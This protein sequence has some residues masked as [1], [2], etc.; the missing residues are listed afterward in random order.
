[1]LRVNKLLRMNMNRTKSG[2]NPVL[3]IHGITD[4]TLVFRQMTAYLS[5]QGFS[6]HSFD[7]TPNNGAMPLD[8][9][10]VQVADYIAKSFDPEQPLDLIGFSMGGIVSRYY[11]QRLGGLERVQRFISIAAPNNGTFTAYLSKRPGCVQMR[12]DSPLLRDLNQDSAM[13]NRLNFTVIWTPYDLMIVPPNSSQMPEAKEV[14]VST[15]FHGWIPADQRCLQ[16]VAKALSEP[17]LV[18]SC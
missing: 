4:T 17:V 9:L 10:A 1:M 12:P 6:V 11:I 5:A 2:R 7:L 18:A 15:R 8:K 13:L 3:L 14:V 16:A